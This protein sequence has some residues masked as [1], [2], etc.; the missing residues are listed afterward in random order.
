MFASLVEQ[1]ANH[2]RRLGLPAGVYCAGLGKKE[3]GGDVVVASIQSV[4][5]RPELLGKVNLAM[6]DEAHLI[7]DANTSMYRTMLAGLRLVNPRLRLLGLTATPY[8][9]ESGLIVGPAGPFHR[10]IYQARLADLISQGYLSPLVSKGAISKIDIDNLKVARGEFEAAQL[11][12]AAETVVEQAGGEIAKYSAGRRAILVFAA[13]VGH[14]KHLAAVLQR[15]DIATECVFGDTPTAERDLIIKRFRS[16]ELRCLVNVRVLTT[17]FD[18]PHV[19]LVAICTATMSKGLLAQMAGRG[20]RLA[21]GKSD[22][23]LLDF[24]GN[25]RR[26]GALDDP[27]DGGEKE[28]VRECPECQRLCRRG[29]NPCPSCGYEWFALRATPVMP[30]VRTFEPKHA[31]TADDVDPILG[32]PQPR[33]EERETFEIERTDYAMHRKRGAGDDHP[34]T[35]RVTHWAGMRRF[36][37]FVC[38]QHQGFART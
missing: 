37:E 5:K 29:E 8:R 10:L 23:L 3:A 31:G 28:D 25:V 26:H 20:L 12:A 34:P 36:N 24:G 16:G 33:A 1:N 7:P 6:I 13:G 9:L 27:L 19:D 15:H 11:E 38:F 32:P 22:C 2:L 30:P 35:M 18:A 14:A 21:P 4:C 17:G